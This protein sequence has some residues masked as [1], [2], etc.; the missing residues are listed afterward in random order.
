ML[1]EQEGEKIKVIDEFTG[2]TMVFQEVKITPVD[3]DNIAFSDNIGL[4][5]IQ[6]YDDFKLSMNKK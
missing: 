1:Q 6:K 3:I 5:L 2:I 4:K